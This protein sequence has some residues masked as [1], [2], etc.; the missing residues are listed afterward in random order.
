MRI[1]NVRRGR[2]YRMGGLCAILLILLYALHNYSRQ[3]ISSDSNVILD[4]NAAAE[5]YK[6]HKDVYPTLKTGKPYNTQN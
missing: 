4:I 5:Y 3:S 6:S 2:I 1:T